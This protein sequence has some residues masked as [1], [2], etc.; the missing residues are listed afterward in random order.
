M[1]KL[2]VVAIILYGSWSYNP[3]SNERVYWLTDHSKGISYTCGFVSVNHLPMSGVAAGQ[4]FNA[5]V[6]RPPNESQIGST[7][8]SEEKA[9]EKYVAAA[10]G[11]ME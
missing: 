1:T 4:G 5:D 6:V 8:F 11:G 9:A 3:S 7:W 2:L 10:C